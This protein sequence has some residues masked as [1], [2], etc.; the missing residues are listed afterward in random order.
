MT[1]ETHITVMKSPEEVESY[2]EDGALVHGLFIEGARWEVDEDE[3][4]YEV[5]GVQCSGQ[6]GESRLK[7]LLPALP[8][9]YVR[10]VP[11]QP[12]W[13]PSSVGYL[14]HEDGIY[15]CPVY[16]TTFRGPTYVFLGTL[17]TGSLNHKWVLGGV[18][19]IMQEDN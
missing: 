17:R 6:L 19:I 7:E 9:A 4:P 2:P 15:E 5:G 18:A 11:V 3:D 10:A 12:H 16:T 13:E 1:L 8:V 14:R